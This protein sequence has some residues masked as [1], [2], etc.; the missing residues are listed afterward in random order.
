MT[1]KWL[2]GQLKGATRALAVAPPQKK[3]QDGTIYPAP[4]LAACTE[5]SL[6]PLDSHRRCYLTLTTVY[7]SKDTS[8]Q[9]PAL[10]LQ[11]NID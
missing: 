7:G 1:N 11:I 5:A 2:V 8:H 6:S 4:D 3:P 10:C 9:D